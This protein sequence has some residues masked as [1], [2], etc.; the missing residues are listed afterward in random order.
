MMVAIPRDF[1]LSPH[2][3]EQL[4]RANPDRRFE[5]DADGQLIEM[6]PTHWQSGRRNQAI[7]TQLGLWFR[8]NQ[9]GAIFDSSTGFRLPNGAI[10]S[11]DAAW[12]TPEQLARA[13]ARGLDEFFPDCPA[14]VIELASA[15]DRPDDLRSKLAEYLSNGCQ[16]GW[17]ILPTFRQIE[18]WR[19]PQ[20]PE[21]LENPEI[22]SA[23]PLL[24]GFSLDLCEI[25]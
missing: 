24:S 4:C 8:H 23:D 6:S 12:V 15:S 9:Q 1:H 22:V 19:S 14:F 7:A 25:W 11:P 20:D 17:L 13:E 18:V 16:L 10:R 5:L 2:Q 3:F 21:C